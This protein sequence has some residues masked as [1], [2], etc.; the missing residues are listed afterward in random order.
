MSWVK[1]FC[2]HFGNLGAYRQCIGGAKYEILER[3]MI[4]PLKSDIISFRVGNVS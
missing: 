2:W 4:N 1:E 3:N